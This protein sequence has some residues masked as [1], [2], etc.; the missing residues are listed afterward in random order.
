MSVLLSR[1][2]SD[3]VGRLAGGDDTAWEEAKRAFDA[4]PEDDIDLFVAI[5]DRDLAAL[6]AI[7]A[8]WQSGKRPLPLHDRNLLKSALKAFR[9]RLKLVNLD[10]DSSLGKGPMSSGR[11]SGIVGVR[12]P[13]QFPP[14]VWAELVRQGRLREGRDGTHELPPDES[15]GE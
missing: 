14:E 1:I 11:H 2:L 8:G 5:D 10:A 6:R 3:V 12:A 7:T 9:K 4:H 15:G 13:D